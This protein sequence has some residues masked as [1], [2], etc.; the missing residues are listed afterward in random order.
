MF[1]RVRQFAKGIGELDAAGVDLET[2]GYTRIIRAGAGKGCFR[3]GIAVP[4]IS[5]SSREPW[6]EI[7]HQ[8]LPGRNGWIECSGQR[9]ELLAGHR[10]CK[11][12]LDSL[13]AFADR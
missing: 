1:D 12:E 4:V 3:N 2:F 8:T 13:A 6:A 10:T 5:L 7:I 11:L 9:L